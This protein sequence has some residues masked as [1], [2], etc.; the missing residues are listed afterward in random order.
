MTTLPQLPMELVSSILMLRESPKHA[1]LIKTYVSEYTELWENGKTK[2][3]V[4]LD[5]A[6]KI[7]KIG[8]PA[9]TAWDQDGN[10]VLEEWVK[11]AKMQRSGSDKPTR[12]LWDSEGKVSHE[13]W[14]NPGDEFPFTKE[15]SHGSAKVWSHTYEI[16][17]DGIIDI[18]AGGPRYVLETDTGKSYEY[19]ESKLEFT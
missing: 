1:Q 13:S 18:D 16:W 11:H 12:T 8:G 3:T 19:P 2:Y 5:S 10:K 9:I 14:F 4:F 6:R 17:L 7:H 15:Y